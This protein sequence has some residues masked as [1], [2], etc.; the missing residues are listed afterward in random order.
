M[1]CTARRPRQRLGLRHRLQ[2]LSELALLLGAYLAHAGQRHVRAQRLGVHLRAQRGQPG[3]QVGVQQL[4]CVVRAHAQP[5]HA[6]GFGV[7]E[8]SQARNLKYLVRERARGFEQV[9][10]DLGLVRLFDIAQEQEC[11]VAVLGRDGARRTL[12]A[13]LMQRLKYLPLGLG[14]VAARGRVGFEGQEQSHS[15]SLAEGTAAH[16]LTWT[17][18]FPCSAFTAS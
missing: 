17:G 2:R 11:Q 10:L 5:Q 15:R 3:A 6:R 12:Q 4:Q 18:C 7:G 1:S 9:A 16:A 14:D 8:G 13:M